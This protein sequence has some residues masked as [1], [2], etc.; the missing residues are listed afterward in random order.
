M[1]GC[2]IFIFLSLFWSLTPKAIGQH[3]EKKFNHEVY[4]A[5]AK[6][7]LRPSSASYV[8]NDIGNYQGALQLNEVALQW[9]LDTI[10]ASEAL[11]IVKPEDYFSTIPGDVSVVIVSEAHQKPQHR[12]F[13]RRILKSLYD[14]GFRYFGLE[15][16]TPNL[17][18]PLFILDSL[19]N[20]RKYPM[21]SPLTGRYAKEPMMGQLIREALDMGFTVF[22]YD[23]YG[24][25]IERDLS[26]ALTI[27]K[28]MDQHPE[29][30]FLIHCGWYH[31]IESNYSKRGDGQYM[32]HHLKQ[33]TGTDPLT[34]Y[35]DVLS[36]KYLHTESPIYNQLNGEMGIVVRN[37]N[38]SPLQLVDH[39][40][41]LVFH[42]RTSFR[43]GRPSYLLNNSGWKAVELSLDEYELAYPVS[44]E[45]TLDTEEIDATPIDR[46]EHLSPYQNLRLVLPPGSFHILITDVKGKEIS[47]KL[48]VD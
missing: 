32:A 21:D 5:M 27:K 48:K 28:M 13:T 20:E 4:D 11:R 15:A 46:M 35:Q 24:G 17:D 25:D 30:K 37:E 8:L 7:E 40:D 41:L 26:Q 2:R 23:K 6:G 39:F 31:A 38:G 12:I 43:Y 34:I 9:G 29:G 45:A 22:G 10:G 33:L 14:Q 16:L 19:L 36:E 18:H 1:K 42:P 3:W 44:I 47:L